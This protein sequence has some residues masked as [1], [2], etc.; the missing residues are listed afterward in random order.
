M[1]SHTSKIGALSL[2]VAWLLA[3]EA[4]PVLAPTATAQPSATPAPTRTA[5][6][7]VTPT[8]YP[9]GKLNTGMG[10]HLSIRGVVRDTLGNVVPHAFVDLQVYG[11]KGGWDIGELG[12]WGM[13][14]D[15]AGQYLFDN[16]VRLERG[17]YEIWFNGSQ[18]YGKAFEN[19][20]YSVEARQVSSDL[21]MLDVTIHPMTKSALAAV[22]KYEDV[23]GFVK[24]FY[25][26]P[27]AEPEPGHYIQL[28]RGSPSKAEYTI[29]GEYGRIS[30]AAE[31]WAGL[32]GGSYFLSFT[33]RRQ[34]GVVVQCNSPAFQILP[35]ETKRL[36]YTI[37][38]C[39]ASSDPLLP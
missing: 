15:A 21:R 16:V 32:A 5:V 14:T 20:G 13:Y 34:D 10:G 3:C 23:D 8:P 18:E 11:A 19:A 39:P 27:F 37:R 1:K 38:N 33:Y 26:P 29:G 35:G 7:S 9:S 6:P 4:L 31:K 12:R 17:H 24:D 36:Q 22:V 2:V 30:G 28:Y 25:A